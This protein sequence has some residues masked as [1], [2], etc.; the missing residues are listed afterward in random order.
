[1]YNRLL[2]NYHNHNQKYDSLLVIYYTFTGPPP[3]RNGAANFGP[4]TDGMVPNFEPLIGLKKGEIC[5]FRSF[6]GPNEPFR[7][8]PHHILCPTGPMKE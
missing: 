2:I 1:M 5:I 4:P 7:L 3:R 6:L 8:F